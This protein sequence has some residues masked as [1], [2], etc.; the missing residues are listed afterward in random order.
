MK[1]EGH[2]LLAR[3]DNLLAQVRIL[4]ARHSQSKHVYMYKTAKRSIG[5]VSK[6]ERVPTIDEVHSSN[7]L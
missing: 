3:G 1:V 4:M 7:R 6:I 2:F 5:T